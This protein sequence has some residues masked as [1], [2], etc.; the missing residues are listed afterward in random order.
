MYFKIA[1]GVQVI[2]SFRKPQS[3]ASKILYYKDGQAFFESQCEFGNTD[4]IPNTAMIGLVV[5]ARGFGLDVPVKVEPTGIQHAVIR[6][7]SRDGGFIVISTTPSSG[8]G[9]KLKPGDVVLWV[10]SVYSEE[11]GLALGDKRSGWIGLIRAKVKPE[12]RTDNPNFIIA[13]RYD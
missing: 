10:P 6:V 13:C 3:D 5:D 2:W 12:I 11:E 4:V 1:M 9:E 7:V 8:R